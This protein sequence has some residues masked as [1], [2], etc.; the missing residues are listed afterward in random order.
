MSFQSLLHQGISLLLVALA[1]GDVGRN[2][3]NPFF[4]RASVYWSRASGGGGRTV[5]SFQSLLHQ[6]I[7]LLGLR[8]NC[9]SNNSRLVSIP[10]SSGH[11]FTDKASR[12]AP[13]RE[14]PGRF[15]PFF[16]RASV[17]CPIPTGRSTLRRLRFNP[18][19]IRASVYCVEEY[20]NKMRKELR[21][22]PFFIRASVY[23]QR[24]S[25]V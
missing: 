19:F 20:N 7:S 6:G 10:S 5:G 2:G 16:I 24:G 18:F 23:C 13:H 25:V 21:F 11:Q 1:G 14:A 12:L 15:N 4:I 22:N 17:Y 8:R 3:F 9:I